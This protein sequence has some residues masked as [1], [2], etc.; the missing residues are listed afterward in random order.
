MV[1]AARMA[2]EFERRGME[3]GKD[4]LEWATYYVHRIKREAPDLWHYIEHERPDLSA[5][6]AGQWLA[7]FLYEHAGSGMTLRNYAADRLDELRAPKMRGVGDAHARYRAPG[8]GIL[9]TPIGDADAP[10]KRS[11]AAAAATACTGSEF[12]SFGVQ[13]CA[14][15][16]RPSLPKIT[17]SRDIY[18]RV[19]ALVNPDAMVREHIG[20]LVLD[21]KLQSLGYYIAGLGT[22]SY[23]GMDPQTVL[24]PVMLMPSSGFV[25]VH[26]HPTG[27]PRPSADDVAFTQRIVNAAS[28]VGTRLIDHVIL[29]HGGNYF[30]MLD[31]GI[32]ASP[33]RG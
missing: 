4:P 1:I 31:A 24:R 26:N 9:V 28:I 27:D 11:R 5:R 33:E 10:K 25:L 29:G 16:R 30:S 19:T 23:V 17:S 8:E 14:S 3:P 21:N 22:T 32:L 13:I 18:E 6:E 20:V 12:D 15:W 7:E 2:L